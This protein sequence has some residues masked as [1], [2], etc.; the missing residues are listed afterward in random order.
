MKKKKK[1]KKTFETMDYHFLDEREMSS[2]QLDPME[3]R[4]TSRTSRNEN[5]K[6]DLIEFVH[7]Q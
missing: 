3:A 5:S 2:D 7:D 4:T 1:K 6:L